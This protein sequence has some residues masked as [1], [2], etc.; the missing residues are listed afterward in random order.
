[1]TKAV[2]TITSGAAVMVVKYTCISETY[3]QTFCVLV[4][5]IEESV[6]GF[7]FSRHLPTCLVAEVYGDWCVFFAALV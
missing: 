7:L 2:E 5:L 3:K 4:F 1:M 6:V